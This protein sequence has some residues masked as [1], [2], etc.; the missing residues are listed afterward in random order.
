M[1]GSGFVPA[2]CLSVKESQ[3]DLEH[4]IMVQRWFVRNGVTIARTELY[5]A[6][7]GAVVAYR[8]NI[9]GE[10]SPLHMDLMFKELYEGEPCFDAILQHAGVLDTNKIQLYCT[11]R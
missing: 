7:N 1:S 5:F 9:N 3:E 4:E 10:N 11:G 6:A 8:D 2:L